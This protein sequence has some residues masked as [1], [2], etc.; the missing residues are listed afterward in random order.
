MTV[1]LPKT[2]ELEKLPLRAIVA[3]AERV[4]RRL[5]IELRGTIA[6]DILDDAFRLIHKVCLNEDVDANAVMC[7]AQRVTSAYAATSGEATSNAQF[8]IVFSICHAAMA[9]MNALLAAENPTRIIY[10]AKRTAIEAERTNR[11]IESL[12]IEAAC[13]AKADAIRDYEAL[14]GEYGEHE[15]VI[16]G[17]PV[18]CF[19]REEN[20]STESGRST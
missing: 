12:S 10:Y 20:R 14:L 2:S 11:A 8:R 7:G 17:N 18:R 9:A 6:D 4:A 1:S 19:E 13:T 16:L 5:S 3:Y 15:E